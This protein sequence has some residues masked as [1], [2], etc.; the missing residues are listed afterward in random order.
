M[1]NVTQQTFPRFPKKEG[2][3]QIEVR[4]E[5]VLQGSQRGPA[6]DSAFDESIYELLSGRE[7]EEVVDADG[8]Q[9]LSRPGQQ[10]HKSTKHVTAQV[11][12]PAGDGFTKA[13]AVKPTGAMGRRPDEVVADPQNFMKRGT[14]KVMPEKSNKKYDRPDVAPRKDRL[15]SA[16]TSRTEPRASPQRRTNFEAENKLS[17]TKMR[18]PPEKKDVNWKKKAGYGKT[19]AYLSKVKD[20]IAQEKEAERLRREE[21]ENAGKPK[22]RELS[23]QEKSELIQGLKENWEA[24]HKEYQKLPVSIRT[25]AQRERKEGY[26]AQMTKIEKDIDKLQRRHVLVAI[27][28][29]EQ[30]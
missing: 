14:G 9:Y 16:L 21:E 20:D 3:D 19:P 17:A 13:A 11:L 28:D 10:R 27:D 23:R 8:R 15:P 4:V 12:G 1:A 5:G 22:L 7:F 24:I 30:I 18:P 26:E 6:P 25:I 2:G 29:D